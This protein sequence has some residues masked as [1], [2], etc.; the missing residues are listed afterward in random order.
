M[1][2]F[3]DKNPS[4]KDYS[5]NTD[6]ASLDHNKDNFDGDNKTENNRHKSPLKNRHINKDKN[7][8]MPCKQCKKE[9]IPRRFKNSSI[10]LCEK[11][12]LLKKQE[13]YEQDIS[14]YGDIE[15]NQINEKLWLGNIEGA[16]SKERLKEIGITHIL[17]V[18]YYLSEFFPNDFKYKTLEV[19]D[20]ETENI[21]DILLPAIEFIYKS[22]K[23]YV[24]CRKGVSRSGSI[25]IAYIMIANKLSYEDAKKFVVEKRNCVDPNPNFVKQLKQFGDILTC[26]NYKYTLVKEFLKTFV[27]EQ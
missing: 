8:S 17:V 7:L 12:Y 15:I 20:C 24:H 1:G 11:C 22:E 3:S 21:I 16:K 9:L 13:K 23:C 19:E 6:K 5:D 26:C 18:G 2:A 25:V 14:Y 4:K 10:L 27:K